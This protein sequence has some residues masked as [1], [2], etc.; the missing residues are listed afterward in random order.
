[1][2]SKSR[3]HCRAL[4][5]YNDHHYHYGYH[6]YAAAVVAKHDPAWG[7]EY[8]DR[9]LLYIRDFAN[10]GAADK[11]FPQFRQKDWFLGSSWASGIV[12]AENSPHGRNE[13]SSSEAIAAYEA[14]ALYGAVMADIF[15]GGSHADDKLEAAKLVRDAGQLLTATELRATNRYWH[16]W[17]SDTHK[18]TYPDAYKQ[19]VVGM[20]YDT[21]ATFQTWFAPWAVV[22]YGIQLMP[23]TAV[24]EKRDDPEWAKVLYPLYEE[25]C[26]TAGDFCIENGWSILQAGLRAEAG[27]HEEALEQT[28]AIAPEV[29]SSDGGNG[30]SLSNMIWFIATRKPSDASPLSS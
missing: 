5:W 12:S 27:D 15:S 26:K 14:V 30:N 8:F 28:M 1:L 21:M 23:F 9:V 22:S 13:E 16:V 11:F 19:P 25:A 2:C 10:P 29:F 3:F 17:S 6:V 7:A 18:T 24:A 4:G 20:L